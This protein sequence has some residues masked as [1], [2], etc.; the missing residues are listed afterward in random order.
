LIGTLWDFSRKQTL[1]G[2]RVANGVSGTILANHEDQWGAMKKPE[3]MGVAD[4]DGDAR[5]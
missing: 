1:T 2:A 4:A 3:T 5:A